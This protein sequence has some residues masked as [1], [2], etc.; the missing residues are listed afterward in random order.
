MPS[1]WELGASLPQ[2][3]PSEGV[4]GAEQRGSQGSQ[5]AAGTIADMLCGL[6]RETPEEAGK[7]WGTR[8]QSGGLVPPTAFRLGTGMAKSGTATPQGPGAWR[9]CRGRDTWPE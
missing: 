7:S 2:P 3:L 9:E 4:G 5:W 6:N 8:R 1:Q